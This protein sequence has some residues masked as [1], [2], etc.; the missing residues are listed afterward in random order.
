MERENDGAVQQVHHGESTYATFTY[1]TSHPSTIILNNYVRNK[2]LHGS[3][4]VYILY[5]FYRRHCIH[6]MCKVDGML[7]TA[8]A[9]IVIVSHS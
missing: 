1:S 7:P 9:I 8:I 6:I 4:K 3:R 5:Y 2:H